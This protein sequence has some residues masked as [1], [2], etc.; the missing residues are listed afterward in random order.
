MQVQI[1]EMQKTLEY[2]N[3]ILVTG[4]DDT[5]SLPEAVRALTTTV[6]LYIKRKDKEEEKSKEQ[7]DRGKWLVLG[8]VIPASLVFIAQAT[9]FFFK[10]VP[11]MNAL[12][13]P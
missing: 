4:T 1:S 5:V 10:F 8:T 11:I 6:D 2:H 7:W 13:N 12:A 9:F 3:K